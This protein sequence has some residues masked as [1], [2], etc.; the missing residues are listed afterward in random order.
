MKYPVDDRGRPGLTAKKRK[1]YY[2]H[3]RKMESASLERD[4]Q[5]VPK[6]GTP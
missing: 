5:Y 4:W 3:M 1:Q 2:A 6:V